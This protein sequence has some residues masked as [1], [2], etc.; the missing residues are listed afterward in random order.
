MFDYPIPPLR[1]SLYTELGLGPEATTE[2]INEARQEL[3]ARLRSRQKSLQRSLDEVYQQLPQLRSTWEQLKALEKAGQDADPQEY[4]EVQ[5]KLSVLEDQAI[6]IRQDFKA[7]RDEASE[8]E[9]RIHAAN[10][11]PIQNPEDRLEYDRAHPPFELMKLADCASCP[12]DSSK[13]M[14]RMVRQEL[15][16]FLEQLG[17]DVFHPSDLT[18]S[19]FQHDFTANPNLDRNS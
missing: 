1:A 10:L 11:M 12:M 9:G 19:E 13:V 15:G 2:E 5:I 8:V 7:V 3:T 14:L 18:R 16:D 17:E 4:R 6:Q